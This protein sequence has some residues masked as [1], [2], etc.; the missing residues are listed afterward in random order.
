M[1]YKRQKV[2]SAMLLGLSFLLATSGAR[3]QDP[4]LRVRQLSADQVGSRLVVRY[5]FSPRS[6]RHV[7]RQLMLHVSARAHRSRAGRTELQ[8][9][10][11]RPR[12]QVDFRLPESMGRARATVWFTLGGIR[13]EPLTLTLGPV[14][15][16]RLELAVAW[17]PGRPPRPPVPVTTLPPPSPPS[18][19]MARPSWASRRE[20]IQA[21][22]AAFSG[23]RNKSSCLETVARSPFPPA[24]IIKACERSMDGDS[25]EL[26][27]LRVAVGARYD[28][29]AALAA[30]DKAMNGDTNELKCLS[31]AVTA[32]YEPAGAI[33]ACEKAMDGDRNALRCIEAAVKAPRDPSS[34]IEACDR[35][36]SGDRS[37][38]EC[39]ERA[40]RLR[41]R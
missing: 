11:D 16:R 4:E 19:P 41:R 30:C 39:I 40:T 7:P 32:R 1:H 38:L 36:T 37:E 18:P 3:A 13:A 23:S 20:V 5:A 17:T 9:A 25:H 10:V 34:A 22:G 28:P 2:L 26:E 33:A 14:R 15:V 21:C 12:G 35:S 8:Q 29:S 24:G 6:W 31:A 27:C